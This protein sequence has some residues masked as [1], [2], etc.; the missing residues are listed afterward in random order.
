MKGN[1][2]ELLKELS[3]VAEEQISRLMQMVVPYI[4]KDTS[5]DLTLS[6]LHSLLAIQD[7]TEREDLVSQASPLLNKTEF[8]SILKAV[9]GIAKA[10]RA[11]VIEKASAFKEN[12]KRGGW[13]E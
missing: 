7:I 1:Q 4:D 13:I 11:D 10:D 6:I 9:Q 2:S 12:L 5:S 8:D 3:N